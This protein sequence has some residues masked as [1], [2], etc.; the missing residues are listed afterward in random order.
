MRRFGRAFVRDS[1]TSVT[2]TNRP[3][4]FL[5]MV[6]RMTHLPCKDFEADRAIRGAELD[7][8]EVVYQRAGRLSSVTT[9]LNGPSLGSR[10]L[11]VHGVGYD[12]VSGM[13]AG[14]GFG[15]R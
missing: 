5:P 4:F 10:G 3:G 6:V 8:D 15:E 12:D 13:E 7:R 11:A 14:V 2:A 1:P 9:S